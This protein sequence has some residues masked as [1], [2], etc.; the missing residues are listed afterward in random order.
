MGSGS[1]NR[2]RTVD[3]RPSLVSGIDRAD[4]AGRVGSADTADMPELVERKGSPSPLARYRGSRF[5]APRSCCMGC[6]LALIGDA[7]VHTFRPD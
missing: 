6:C 5:P 1:V 2:P 4:K 3:V 7:P